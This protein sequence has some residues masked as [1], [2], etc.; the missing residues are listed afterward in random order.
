MN[1]KL[2]TVLLPLIII[3]L[4]ACGGSKEATSEEAQRKAIETFLESFTKEGKSR[5]II[6]L[7]PERS[8]YY[9]GEDGTVTF[10][11]IIPKDRMTELG[12]SADSIKKKIDIIDA[13]GKVCAEISPESLSMDEQGNVL[14]DVSFVIDTKEDGAYSFYART[15]DYSS[16]L[17]TIYVT[18]HITEKQTIEALE[19]GGDLT[20]FLEDNYSEEDSDNTLVEAAKSFLEQDE[21]VAQVLTEGTAVT[22]TTSAGIISVFNAKATDPELLSE[23]SE[24]AEEFETETQTTSLY[25]QYGDGVSVQ[26]AD[27]PVRLDVGNTLSNG[28][29]LILRPATNAMKDVQMWQLKSAAKKISKITDS[30]IVTEY[31][32]DEVV[33]AVMS[34]ELVN[35]GTVMLQT[36]GAKLTKQVNGVSTTCGVSYLMY[37][38][39]TFRENTIANNLEEKMRE[40]SQMEYEISSGSGSQDQLDEF[41]RQFYGRIGEPDTWRM[42]F[43]YARDRDESVGLRFVGDIAI[44]S[45]YLMERYATASFDNTVFYIGACYGVSYPSFDEWLLNH[46]CQVVLGYS[47]SVNVNMSLLD[48]NDLFDQLTANSNRV[49]WR[50]EDLSEASENNENRIIN[51]FENIPQESLRKISEWINKSTEML[52]IGNDGFFYRGDGTL[53]GSVYYRYIFEEGRTE[54]RPCVG[55]SV[56]PHLFK[57][58]AFEEKSEVKTD[59]NG[60]FSFEK[61]RCGNYAIEVKNDLNQESVV[62]IVFD[63]E[64]LDGGKIYLPGPSLRGKVIEKQTGKPIEGAAVELTGKR[65]GDKHELMTDEEGVWEWIYA[66]QQY[67]VVISYEDYSDVVYSDVIPSTNQDIIVTEMQSFDWYR[68]IDEE[69][70]PQYG[71]ADSEQMSCEIDYTDYSRMHENW[72]YWN[73]RDGI[74]SADIADFTGDGEDDL[75]LYRFVDRTNNNKYYHITA[76]LYTWEDGEVSCKGNQDIGY[77][78]ISGARIDHVGGD[79]YTYFRIGLVDYNGRPCILTEI[80]YNPY[81]FTGGIFDATLTGWDGER[82]CRISEVGKICG[83]S[84]CIAYGISTYEGGDLISRK[85]LWVDGDFWDS[86]ERFPEYY[87]LIEAT[88]GDNCANAYEGVKEGY[89]RLGLPEPGDSYFEYSEWGLGGGSGM[90]PS[91]WDTDSMKKTLEFGV[92]GPGDKYHRSLVDVVYDYTELMERVSY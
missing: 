82:F 9:T 80:N 35:Y 21:R 32:D 64:S 29:V 34:G 88:R 92:K 20:A 68:Y 8:S 15:E 5:C 74:V 55:A 13:A 26:T 70:E 60:S 1:K 78:E 30:S 39:K 87:Q 72:V 43:S 4:T 10:S 63:Q 83:G 53:D 49:A 17:T 46:G 76:E 66:T 81:K 42:Y 59:N 45:G 6:R 52:L 75:V 69:L 89:R 18:P 90:F 85:A 79:K 25:R 33:R 12:V 65:D 54:E 67:N 16:A 73:Q 71:Y 7:M 22:F 40:Y 11:V 37:R 31:K 51:L 86:Y 19:V 44:T 58:Q 3:T 28:N 56:T 50:T 84:N 47:N 61:L 36:H 2:I 57:N 62:S 23:S 38:E 91:Y 27:G 77:F 24:T 14:G 41:Y 48:F